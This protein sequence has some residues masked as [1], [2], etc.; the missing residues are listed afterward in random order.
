MKRFATFAL[1]AALLVAVIPITCFAE[2]ADEQTV[3]TYFDDGSYID[4]K[5]SVVQSRASGTTSGTKDATY[6][7][8]GG[9]AEWKATLT[10]TFTYTGSSATCTASSISVTIYDSD[11]YTSSKSASKSGNSANGSVTMGKK[12]LGVTVSTVSKDVTL[13]CDANGNLS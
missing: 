4:E 3:I 2:S 5:I 9:S 7:G 12:L 8:S 13:K 6:Y 11:W 1:L 10:G